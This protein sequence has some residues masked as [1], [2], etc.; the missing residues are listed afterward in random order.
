[1]LSGPL[2]RKMQGEVEKPRRCVQ[3]R[4]ASWKLESEARCLIKKLTA[5]VGWDCG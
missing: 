3:S 1:M 5:E 2:C 4:S